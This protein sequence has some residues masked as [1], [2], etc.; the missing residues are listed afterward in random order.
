MTRIT[1]L[2]V[3]WSGDR[4]LSS[5]ATSLLDDS[6]PASLVRLWNVN[7]GRELTTFEVKAHISIA[8]FTTPTS[9]SRLAFACKDDALVIWDTR[10]RRPVRSLEVSKAITCLTLARHGQLAV[11]STQDGTLA[12]WDVSTGKMVRQLQRR[13][14]AAITALA[15]CPQERYALAGSSDGHVGLWNL[16]NGAIVRCFTG[17]GSR[18]LGVGFSR[19]GDFAMAGDATGAIRVWQTN[20]GQQR[21]GI[22]IPAERRLDLMALATGERLILTVTDGIV[23]S[24]TY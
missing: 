11:I 19:K 2:T 4:A 6:Q 20:S 15:V 12:M 13:D 3:S 17:Q 14:I 5:Q 24:W 21:Q 22:L 8:A 18:V 16:G 9:Y 23:S 1:G 7:T 10:N